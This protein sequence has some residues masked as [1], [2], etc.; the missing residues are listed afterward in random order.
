MI[1]KF[2]FEEEVWESFAYNGFDFPFATS[3]TASTSLSNLTNK[4]NLFFVGGTNT[5]EA[6]KLVQPIQIDGTK[7]NFVLNH[8]KTENKMRFGRFSPTLGLIK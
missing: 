5:Q 2:N 3:C 8:L 7:H 1:E 6:T 4:R